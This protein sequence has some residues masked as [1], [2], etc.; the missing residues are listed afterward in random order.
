MVFQMAKLAVIWCFVGSFCEMCWG[1][2][3]G[4]FLLKHSVIKLDM[5]SV[6]CECMYGLCVC[7]FVYQCVFMCVCLCVC[8]RASV[9]ACTFVCLVCVYVCVAKHPFI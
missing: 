8:A 1:G 4:N 5:S 3:G 2:G 6:A 7:M 9:H